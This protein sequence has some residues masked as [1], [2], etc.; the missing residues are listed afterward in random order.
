ML[1]EF[2]VALGAVGKATF[3]TK[4]REV[5]KIFGPEVVSAVE[6][7]LI[8]IDQTR[9][10]LKVLDA[11]VKRLALA[12]PSSCRLMT[13]PGVGPV[14]T[15]SFVAEIDDIHRFKS[16]CSRGLWIRSKGL[17]LTLYERFRALQEALKANPDTKLIDLLPL[18]NQEM[19][20]GYRAQLEQNK[21][22]IQRFCDLT[23]DQYQRAKGSTL[24]MTSTSLRGAYRTSE[25]YH[26]HGWTVASAREDLKRIL[27]AHTTRDA[28]AED[29]VSD[30]GRILKT[31]DLPEV[32]NSVLEAIDFSSL[33][34]DSQ[35]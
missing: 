20:V 7:M 5:I 6:P 22:A 15:L 35:A 2:G 33:S 19:G 24:S 29:L 28:I 3:T 27:V 21:S 31:L 32:S 4:V 34:K 11:Q 17:L 25:E 10:Q 18:I 13:I 9:E 14:T 26:Q 12:N 1:K 30:E 16:S 23:K 8:L